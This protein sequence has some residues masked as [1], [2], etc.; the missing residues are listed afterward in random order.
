MKLLSGLLSVTSSN[1]FRGTC[2]GHAL[3][4]SLTKFAPSLMPKRPA[5]TT[6]RFKNGARATPEEVHRQCRLV[7][8][9]YPP[10]PFRL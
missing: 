2:Y 3:P 7:G 5:L 4:G 6:R 10:S 9:P 1:G 8:R